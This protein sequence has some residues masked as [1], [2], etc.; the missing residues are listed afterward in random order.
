MRAEG[1]GAGGDLEV[2]LGSCAG[3]LDG[4]REGGE[5]IGEA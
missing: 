1:E 4:E 5:G 3:E 2:G